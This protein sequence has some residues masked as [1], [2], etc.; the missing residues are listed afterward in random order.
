[1]QC[2]LQKSGGRLEWDLENN[3]SYT[4]IPDGFHKESAREK[5]LIR[6][7]KRKKKT[8]LCHSCARAN[9][10]WQDNKH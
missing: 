9:P 10:T 5:T 8:Q 1:M 4:H 3:D 6:G 2:G 7:R